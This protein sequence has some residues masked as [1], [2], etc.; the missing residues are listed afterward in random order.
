[1]LE[2]KD[3]EAGKVYVIKAHKGS[4]LVSYTFVVEENVNNQINGYD[5]GDTH[6]WHLR[7]NAYSGHYELKEVT[8]EK[9]PEYFL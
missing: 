2:I 1:M 6:K 7:H 9:N 3:C 8:K 4:E 5:F